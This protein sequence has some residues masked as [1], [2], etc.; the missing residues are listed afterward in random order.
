MANYKSDNVTLA[1]PAE[2]VFDKLSNLEGLKEMLAR[3]PSEDI[4][5]EHRTTFENLEITPDAITL[6][7]GPVGALT[8]RMKRKERPGLIELAGEG[9][10][11][12]MSLTL[13]IRPLPGDMSEARAEVD[14]AIP[15]MLAPMVS[16]P[17]KKMVGQFGEMLR[18]IPYD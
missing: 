10:P 13:H 4:P 6:P 18:A 5:E 8:L 16:G 3:V 15:A 11:V 2:R 17:M 14:L 9:T 12:P 7:G 1:A